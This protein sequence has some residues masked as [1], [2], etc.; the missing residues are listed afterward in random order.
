MSAKK[1]KKVGDSLFATL[2]HSS[3]CYFSV[4]WFPDV[5]IIFL[6]KESKQMPLLVG[7]FQFFNLL[8]KLLKNVFIK[9]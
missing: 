4:G 2:A 6:K 9:D 1:F 5:L 7:Q 8:T 3:N